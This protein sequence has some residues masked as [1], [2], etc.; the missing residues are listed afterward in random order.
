M[1]AGTHTNNFYKRQPF[2]EIES[3]NNEIKRINIDK[4][5]YLEIE[6]LSTIKPN[7]S[8]LGSII[9]IKPQGA[10]IGLLYDDSIRSLLGFH[11]TILYKETNSS[12]IRVDI[13]SIDNIFLECD[14]ATGMIFKSKKSGKIRNF[15]MDVDPGYKCIEKFRGGVQWYMMESKDYISSISFKLRNENG[16]LVSFNGQPISFR[17]SIREI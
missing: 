3:L 6:N 5:H 15:T 13:L 10:I 8:R 12:P 11:G 14:I 9:E 17:F 7:F 2:N 4:G 1:K 16:N